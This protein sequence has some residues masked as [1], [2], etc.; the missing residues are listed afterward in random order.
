MLKDWILPAWHL[1]NDLS[2]SERQISLFFTRRFSRFQDYFFTAGA[3]V[4]SPSWTPGSVSSSGA[5]WPAHVFCP[6]S[7]FGVSWKWLMQND[8]GS[9]R[10]D[11]RLLHVSRDEY[12]WSAIWSVVMMWIWITLVQEILAVRRPQ[13]LFFWH[14]AYF[15][16]EESLR[17]KEW[18]CGHDVIFPPKIS[19]CV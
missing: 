4:E 10:V 14:L 16:E 7:F 5:D 13:E 3:W 17:S 11:G 8:F 1:L 18:R 15:A 19:G 9:G 2:E 6:L 12:F